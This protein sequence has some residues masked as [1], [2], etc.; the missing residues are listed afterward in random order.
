MIILFLVKLLSD[1]HPKTASNNKSLQTSPPVF[2]RQL[3]KKKKQFTQQH[4]PQL[5]EFFLPFLRPAF[6][7]AASLIPSMLI[8]SNISYRTDSFLLLKL[9]YI[10]SFTTTK[11]TFSQVYS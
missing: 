10:A 7:T 3:K 5:L 2:Y 8:I 6:L 9:R 4:K 1:Q 11:T